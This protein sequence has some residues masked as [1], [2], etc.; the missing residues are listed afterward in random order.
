[1]TKAS[2][3]VLD[4]SLNINNKEELNYIQNVSVLYVPISIGQDY[5]EQEKLSE[6]LEL[7]KKNLKKTILVKV[8][9]V[10]TPQRYHLAIKNEVTPES[11][12]M[13][14]KENGNSWEKAY[15]APIENKLDH[16]V[17]FIKWDSWLTHT[18]YAEA[19]KEIDFLYNQ[20]CSFKDNL[21]Q[22]VL[23]FER[24]HFNREKRRFT[25]IEKEYCRNCIKEECAV[26]I[27]WGRNEVCPGYH[28]LFYPKLM[29]KALSFVK[30][31]F[32]QFIS[33][34]AVI[35]IKSDNNLFYRPFIK[36]SKVDNNRDEFV[37]LKN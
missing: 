8:I 4:K 34:S 17:E 33:L 23:E 12:Y 22:D 25:E 19:Q 18:Y 30:K 9:I 37:S 20:D 32:T 21:E 29:T 14:A 11:M 31:N 10:D 36:E 27:V 7:I 5:H 28:C 13:A 3:L 1:M 26:L 16:N 35:K 2:K 24:R 6:S 15:K